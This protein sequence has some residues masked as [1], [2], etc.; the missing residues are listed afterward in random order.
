MWYAVG[1]P[2][3][4]VWPARN[5]VNVVYGGPVSRARA[6]S[7]RYREE[8]APARGYQNFGNQPISEYEYRWLSSQHRGDYPAPIDHQYSENSR[9]QVARPQKYRYFTSLPT[10][11]DPHYASLPPPRKPKETTKRITE[12]IVPEHIQ[13]S[14]R[15]SGIFPVAEWRGRVYVLLGCED[16]HHKTRRQED[17]QVWMNAGG[18]REAS[19]T[20]CVTALREF[21]EETRG[22]FLTEEANLKHQLEHEGTPKYWIKNGKYVLFVCKIAF[23]EDINAEFEFRKPAVLSSRA[24]HLEVQWV[25]FEII[26]DAARRRLRTVTFNGREQHLYSF[27]LEMLEEINLLDDGLKH[28]ESVA[29]RERL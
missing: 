29:T 13:R 22:L 19:E 18:K 4:V 15:A 10:R 5:G 25:P 23:L 28:I 2:D 1:S 17:C 26:V 3:S 14:Y 16:R 12:P 9:T 27:F 21:N 7:D 11:N 24:K 20:P 8:S 6:I